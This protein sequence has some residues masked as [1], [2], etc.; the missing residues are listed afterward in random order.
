[1]CLIDKAVRIF[2]ISENIHALSSG[3]VVRAVLFVG[4]AR[5]Q[6]PMPCVL[7]F[8]AFLNVWFRSLHELI[9]TGATCECQLQSVSSMM[10][11]EWN[12]FLCEFC[13]VIFGHLVVFLFGASKC[14]QAKEKVT[15]LTG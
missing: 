6:A 15:Y 13:D 3:R 14:E 12:I 11:E 9:V 1:M 8:R 4:E 5:L 2:F 7:T 10:I